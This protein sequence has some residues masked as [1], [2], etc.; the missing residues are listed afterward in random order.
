MKMYNNVSVYLKTFLVLKRAFYFLIT[1]T[2]TYN[3]TSKAFIF[4]K[5]PHRQ[6]EPV[7]NEDHKIQ[8]ELIKML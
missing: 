1:Y 2:S 8:L 5:H 6:E 3:V 7:K 4:S